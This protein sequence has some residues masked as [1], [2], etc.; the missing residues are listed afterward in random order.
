MFCGCKT[1]ADGLSKRKNKPDHTQNLRWGE[2]DE[3]D[4]ERL[5]YDDA[6]D[7]IEK[8]EEMRKM[9]EEIR[10]AVKDLKNDEKVKI[11]STFLKYEKKDG[12]LYLVTADGSKLLINKQKKIS[13]KKGTPVY[14]E[15]IEHITRCSYG[16]PLWIKYSMVKLSV[17]VK[18]KD[19][20]LYP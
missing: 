7:S 15:V 12:K 6:D 5:P 9:M 10:L 13:I 14:A 8:M 20:T 2:P 18:G 1:N 19:I 11:N 3:D 4:A 16:S 17:K